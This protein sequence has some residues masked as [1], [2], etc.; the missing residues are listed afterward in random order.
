[1]NQIGGIP[2][3]DPR[4]VSVETGHREGAVVQQQ[5]ACKVRDFD[6]NTGDEPTDVTS[7]ADDLRFLGCSNRIAVDAARHLVGRANPRK[8]EVRWDV[9]VVDGNGPH[10]NLTTGVVIDTE[11]AV[12]RP[13]GHGVFARWQITNQPF[14]RPTRRASLEELLL[15]VTWTVDVEPNLFHVAAL[16]ALVWIRGSSLEQH[17]SSAVGA[18]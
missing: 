3:G 2:V 1:M 8:L 16:N 14:V 11:I 6:F 5:T 10:L 4:S 12:S 9:F 13:N 18:A 15:H 17:L 7:D